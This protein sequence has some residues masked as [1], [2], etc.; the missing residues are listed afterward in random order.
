[1]IKT[2]IYIMREYSY[3]NMAL[4]LSAFILAEVRT[5]FDIIDIVTLQK[6]VIQE[7]RERHLKLR[8]LFEES[9]EEVSRFKL[10]HM[11]MQSA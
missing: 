2:I 6:F 5:M 8:I 4:E 11:N 9:G 10:D 7:F 1:L 3:C